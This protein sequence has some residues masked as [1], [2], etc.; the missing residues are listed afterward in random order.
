MPGTTI[1]EK[2]TLAAMAAS[3][4]RLVGFTASTMI[5]LYAW[6]LGCRK[7]PLPSSIFSVYISV[8]KEPSAF[9]NLSRTSTS[10]TSLLS[11]KKPTPIF[12][13]MV[14]MEVI[15]FDAVRGLLALPVRHTHAPRA[16]II[17]NLL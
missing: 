7:W 17:S 16:T 12:R 13:S 10:K 6:G 2:D 5:S 8:L 15:R 3:G 11:V 1:S 4:L 14:F 9:R